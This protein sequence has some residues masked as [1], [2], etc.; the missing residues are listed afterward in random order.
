MD[1]ETLEILLMMKKII[2]LDERMTSA[3][4]GL[5]RKYNNQDEK[6]FKEALSQRRKIE[7]GLRNK[8]KISKKK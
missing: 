5:Y 1:E 3:R 7:W 6:R 4:F 8:L 2:E